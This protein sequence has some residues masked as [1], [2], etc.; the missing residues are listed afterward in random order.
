MHRFFTGWIWR[1]EQCNLVHVRNIEESI[2]DCAGPFVKKNRLN[3][4]RMIKIASI[5]WISLVSSSFCDS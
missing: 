3:G 5:H 1:K 2:L 4:S